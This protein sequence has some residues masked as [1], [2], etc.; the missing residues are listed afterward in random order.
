MM[1]KVIE[2]EAISKQFGKQMAVDRVTISISQGEIYGFLGLNGAGKTTLIRMLLGMI[3]PTQGHALINGLK[4]DGR[5]YNLWKDVG[6]MVETPNAYPDLTVYENLEIFRRLRN[7]KTKESTMYIIEK[8]GLVPFI[9]KRAKDLSLGNKQRLGL[10]KA[11]IHQPKILLL[12]EPTNGLDPAGIVE[13]RNYLKDLATEHG[14]TILL[15]SHLLSEI[16][17]TASR[18]GII[19]NGRMISECK[20]HDLDSIQNKKLWIHTTNNSSAKSILEKNRIQVDIME[21]QL[22][23]KNK[24]A[25]NSPEDIATLLVKNNCPPKSLRVESE[26]L[27]SLFLRLIGQRED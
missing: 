1:N 24:N 8:L 6:Y 3:K 2:T 19:H 4:V 11:L 14:V 26:D 15:S 22:V 23:C 17:K 25:I 13:I 5:N 20:T 18:I 7:L 21:N 10:A 27:E 16:S 12:D 9:N